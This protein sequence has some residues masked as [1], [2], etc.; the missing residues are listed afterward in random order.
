MPGCIFDFYPRLGKLQSNIVEIIDFLIR[1]VLLFGWSIAFFSDGNGQRVAQ[2]GVGFSDNEKAAL[3]GLFVANETISTKYFKKP[4]A[5]NGPAFGG[6]A[7]TVFQC[8]GSQ[9]A[10]ADHHAM[11]NADEFHVGKH[12]ART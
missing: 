12:R 8:A 6:I 2:V 9:S 10:F 1:I 7:G 11:W 5:C 3:R 4:I